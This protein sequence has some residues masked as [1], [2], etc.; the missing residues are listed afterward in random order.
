MRLF[1]LTLA[2]AGVLAMSGLPA[3]DGGTR[4]TMLRQFV[5]ARTIAPGVLPIADR[6]ARWTE[7][8]SLLLLA[9][10]MFGAALV[11]GRRRS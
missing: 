3:R 10:G 4:A 7:C 8:G 1:L 11:V 9:T 5:A 2:M 6:N